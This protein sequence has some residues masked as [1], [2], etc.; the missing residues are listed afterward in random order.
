MDEPEE[1]GHHRGDAVEVS[2]PRRAVEPIREIPDVHVG[3]VTSRVEGLLG[4]EQQIDALRLALPR[5]AL[6]IAW[7]AREVL[8]RSELERVHEDRDHAHVG[9]R[10]R[11]PHERSVSF[12]EEAHRRHEPDRAPVRAE[13]LRARGDLSE[14][15]DDLHR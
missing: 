8:A 1:P 9:P 2:G 15:A 3:R 11:D 5:I 7:V 4:Q 13:R 10:A 12:V 6:G 14:R